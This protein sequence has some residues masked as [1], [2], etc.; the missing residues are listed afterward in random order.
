[1]AIKATMHIVAHPS[2]P[3]SPP[4]GSGDSFPDTACS[5]GP[6]LEAVTFTLPDHSDSGTPPRSPGQRSLLRNATPPPPSPR[7][8][9]QEGF[10]MVAHGLSPG[11]MQ[12]GV[13]PTN[14][15]AF[16]QLMT[17]LLPMS[18][19]AL[20]TPPTYHRRCQNHGFSV[21]RRSIW[22]AKR[23]CTTL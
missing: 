20:P 16:V 21:A 7:R 8:C 12:E 6:V 11:D 10:V 18:A 14:P 4:I 1:M 22:L 19:A 9:T 5:E 2:V 3:S 23:R 17:K 13:I 15:M